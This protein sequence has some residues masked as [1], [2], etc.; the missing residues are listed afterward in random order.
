MSQ[1]M[2]YENRKV[3]A[4]LVP[5]GMYGRY[6]RYYGSTRTGRT[7]SFDSPFC[8]DKRIKCLANHGAH[9]ANPPLF[10]L[11]KRELQ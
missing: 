7:G 2:F 11:L 10:S 4:C 8:S 6:C 9:T 3:S 5:Y 1:D